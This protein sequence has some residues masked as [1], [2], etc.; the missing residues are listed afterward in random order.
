MTG[1]S[2][3]QEDSSNDP[4]GQGF[5]SGNVE[6]LAGD[7]YVSN[8]ANKWQQQKSG[9]VIIDAVIDDG[10]DEP[11]YSTSETYDQTNLFA[12]AWKGG[13]QSKVT[14]SS[15]FNDAN[16]LTEETDMSDA[17]RRAQELLADDP[18]LRYMATIAQSNPK[19]REA[20]EACMGNPS[21]FGQYLNDPEIGPI[22]EAM[23]KSI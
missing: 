3:P 6:V 16:N 20:V 4:E 10:Q 15:T 17:I 13:P 21:A 2:K 8:G 11:S 12:E 14:K 5:K 9:A 7:E 18:K 1:R 19:V 23:R 22:L